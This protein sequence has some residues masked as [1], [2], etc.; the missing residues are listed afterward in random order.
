MSEAA[1][2]ERAAAIVGPSR[3]LTEPSDTEGFQRD[4]R[5]R[6]RGEALAVLMVESAA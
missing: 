4:W 1:L 5:G 6:Y 2:L 3:V